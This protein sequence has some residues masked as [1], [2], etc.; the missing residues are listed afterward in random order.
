MTKPTSKNQVE[1]TDHSTTAPTQKISLM[2]TPCRCEFC[3]KVDVAS[4]VLVMD[5]GNEFIYCNI[6]GVWWGIGH[7]C[8]EFL[9]KAR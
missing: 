9:S 2:M 6:D 4:G 5:D 7:T 3:A 8:P 1:T